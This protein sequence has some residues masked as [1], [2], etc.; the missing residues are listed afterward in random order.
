MSNSGN[1][2]VNYMDLI[3]SYDSNKRNNSRTSK[4]RKRSQKPRRKIPKKSQEENNTNSFQNYQKRNQPSLDSNTSQGSLTFS[5]PVANQSLR[6]KALR[7]RNNL[8]KSKL[9]NLSTEVNDVR[10]EREK[11]FHKKFEKQII[12]TSKEFQFQ[13]EKNAKE[14]FKITLIILIITIS[15]TF[16]TFL[17]SSLSQEKINYCDN[18]G[19]NSEDCTQCPPIAICKN[20]RI[21]KCSTHIYKLKNGK[22]VY[23]EE[24]FKREMQVAQELVQI[25]SRKRGD[26]ECDKKIN[27]KMSNR[28]VEEY[29][30]SRFK[31]KGWQFRDTYRVKKFLSGDKFSAMGVKIEKRGL[32]F[33]IYSEISD[34]SFTCNFKIYYRKNKFLVLGSGILAVFLVYILI[35]LQLKLRVFDQARLAF[36]EAVHILSECRYRELAKIYLEEKL[37]KRGFLEKGDEEVMGYFDLIRE[38]DDRMGIGIMEI[39]GVKDY[40]YFL[41]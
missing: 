30:K 4:E 7:E 11:N 23:D 26:F 38:N 32:G 36:E 28:E 27:F 22:C 10:Q 35:R 41:Y 39:N 15:I 17:I 8:E 3:K 25:L 34:P 1:Q 16:G 5:R 13:E 20:G 33:V 37:I 29:F 40:Y 18:I 9:R 31:T 19:I 12:R 6:E 24:E 14:C 21:V 2:E